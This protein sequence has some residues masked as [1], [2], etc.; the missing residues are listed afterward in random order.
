MGVAL[1][2]VAMGAEA[3]AAVAPVAEARGRKTRC[4]LEPTV[5]PGRDDRPWGVGQAG[6]LT[7]ERSHIPADPTAAPS[8]HKA[9]RGCQLD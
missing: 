5:T 3:L 9:Q 7:Q 8:K 6:A 4:A 2:A 1:A